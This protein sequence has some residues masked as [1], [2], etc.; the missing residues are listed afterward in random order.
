MAPLQ[1]RAWYGLGIGIVWV[2]AIIVVFIVNGGVSTFSEDTGFRVIL[3]GLFVGGLIANFLVMR[4]PSQVDERDKL[5]MDRAPK[6][7]LWAVFIA[8]IVWSI[9]LTE[10]YWDEGQIPVSFPYLMVNS[11]FIVNVL[12]QSLGILI[13]YWRMGRND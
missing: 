4:K 8:L 13:G 9:N 12:A 10:I 2:I 6:V 3:A 7:Q 1:K 11:L 5:I